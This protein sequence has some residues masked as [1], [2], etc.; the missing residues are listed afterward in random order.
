METM[1]V[2]TLVMKPM[3]TAPKQRCQLWDLVKANSFNVSQMAIV[4]QNY[5]YAMGRRIARMAAM[6]KAA[7][8]RFGSVMPRLNLHVKIQGD[9]LAMRGYVME[10]LIVR[11]ILMR[12]TAKGIYVDHPNSPVPTIPPSACSP[13]SS[14]MVEEIV[15][16][17][18]TKAKFVMNV[19]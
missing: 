11:T 3:P 15:L 5:G 16:M 4:S 13:R 1:T 18:P 17:D 9:A 7:M 8:E 6:R 19:T 10:I 12:I 14:A 2:K